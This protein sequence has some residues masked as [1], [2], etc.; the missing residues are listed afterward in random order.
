[1]RAPGFE[2]CQPGT[3]QLRTAQHERASAHEGGVLSLSSSETH[4][5]N[6]TAGGD[7]S[8]KPLIR[9]SCGTMFTDR[10]ARVVWAC[11]DE[12][13]VQTTIQREVTAFLSASL[14]RFSSTHQLSAARLPHA[15]RL[16]GSV[17]LTRLGECLLHLGRPSRKAG[18]V[19]RR[20]SAHL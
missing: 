11:Q 19:A 2:D 14:F 16:V 10:Y 13:T 12:T 17:S 4:S 1:M 8:H 9:D 18:V 15:Q 3:E 5:V 6:G 20:P 7:R